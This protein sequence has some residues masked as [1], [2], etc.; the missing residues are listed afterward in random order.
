M[1]LFKNKLY[2]GK[3]KKLIPVDKFL[4][5]FREVFPAF[6]N[7]GGVILAQAARGHRGLTGAGRN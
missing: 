3:E 2:L 5:L 4:I 6:K 1:N 7:D